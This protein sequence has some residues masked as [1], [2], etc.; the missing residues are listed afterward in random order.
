MRQ[1]ATYLINIKKLVRDHNIDS[2]TKDFNKLKTTKPGKINKTCLPPAPY[3]FPESNKDRTLIFESRFETGN[4]LAAMKI[5][6]GEYDLVLQNDINTNGHTQWFFFR[7]SNTFKGQTVKFN[8]LN[9]AKPDSLYNFGMR[10]LSYS[11]CSRQG[12]Q[13][14]GWHRVGKDIDYSQNTL[15][16]ENTRFTRYYYT[17]TWTYTFDHDAD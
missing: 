12:D 1:I 10:I 2:E 16:R 15:K 17:L 11:V 14:L 13:E 3:Y 6:N 9:L 7:V 4:L 5:S 8:I